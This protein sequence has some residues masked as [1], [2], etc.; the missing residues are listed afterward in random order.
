MTNRFESF[1]PPTYDEW[2]KKIETDLKGKSMDIL[3]S[4]PESDL[5]I[6]AYHHAQTT[7]QN[8]PSITRANN[9][10]NNQWNIRQFFNGENE[11]ELN[12]KILTALNEGCNHIGFSI[13]K[14][15]NQQQLTNQILFEYI[16]SDFTFDD[17]QTAIDFKAPINSYLN[18]DIIAQNAKSGNWT[19]EMEQFYTFFKQHPNNRS[20]WVDSSIFGA[21]GVTSTQELTLMA[22]HVNEYVQFLRD[23]GETLN[24]IN[25]KLIVQLSVNANYFVNIAKFRVA[26]LLIELI[27]T[28]HDNNYTPNPVP[29]FAKTNIRH[30]AKNDKNNNPLRETTQAMSAIIGGCDVL[31]V[32]YGNYGTPKEIDRFERIAK[33]IQLILKEEAYLD[34][35]IDPSAGSY[36]IESLTAQL[37]EKSWTN[38]LALE[39][40]GG[41]IK[42]IK[43]NEIGKMVKQ[44]QQLLTEELN[45]KTTTFLGVN[46]YPNGTENWINSSHQKE[47]K[48]NTAF[49]PIQPFY[50]ET[51]FNKEEV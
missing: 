24:T 21:A 13:K 12:H 35:V 1:T 29:I 18:F 23:K 36:Y 4:K 39:D 17:Y 3:L 34:K 49:T 44:A 27:L 31:T 19:Q 41:L 11:K 20:I 40:N 5:Q 25:E 22:L 15:T 47:E 48:E 46:K 14:D 38:F 45:T 2:L 51:A 33:N 43:S 28:G 8:T 9:A 37:L 32:E 16:G 30:L 6:Q 10:E 50:L 26:R 42:L 7:P